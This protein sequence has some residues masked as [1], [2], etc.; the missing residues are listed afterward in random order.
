[1]KHTILPQVVLK[2]VKDN[3]TKIMAIIFNLSNIF[4]WTSSF[5]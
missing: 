4:F 3:Q 2:C 5:I 1:M